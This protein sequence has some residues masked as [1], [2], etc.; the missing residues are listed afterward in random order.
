MTIVMMMV[1][2]IKAMNMAMMMMMMMMKIP[3]IMKIMVILMVVISFC[4]QSQRTIQILSERFIY[5]ILFLFLS[6]S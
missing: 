1:K 4:Y 3:K 5:I 2:M 6:I